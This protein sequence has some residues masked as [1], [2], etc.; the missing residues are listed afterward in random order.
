MAEC[1][2]VGTRRSPRR[3]FKNSPSN[4]DEIPTGVIEPPKF[5]RRV[6]RS[7]ADRSFAASSEPSCMGLHAIA[8]AGCREP[9]SQATFILFLVA[10]WGGPLQPPGNCSGC[11][12]RK[13]QWRLARKSMWTWNKDSEVAYSDDDTA[14][15]LARSIRETWTARPARPNRDRG[16]RIH[17]CGTEDRQDPETTSRLAPHASVGLPAPG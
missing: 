5:H 6:V 15:D 11:C 4:H 12:S 2:L 14:T 9:G 3:E 10:L 8:L 7:G 16:W 1:G 17:S 13:T